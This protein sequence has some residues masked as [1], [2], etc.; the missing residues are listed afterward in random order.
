MACTKY[1]G[2]SSCTQC[3]LCRDLILTLI[4]SSSDLQVK[5]V[6]QEHCSFSKTDSWGPLRVVCA[7]EWVGVSNVFACLLGGEMS[8]NCS[9]GFESTVVIKKPVFG[10][11]KKRVWGTCDGFTFADLAITI[12]T[13]FPTLVDLFLRTCIIGLGNATC[14]TTL[15]S[16][17]VTS[18]C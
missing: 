13:S 11:Q 10:G 6:W 4:Y 18:C 12:I 7:C 9:L 16:T 2:C 3:S 5:T 8:L 17:G 14:V 1:T 15:V